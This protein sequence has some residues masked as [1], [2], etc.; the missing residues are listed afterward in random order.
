[1]RRRLLPKQVAYLLGHTTADQVRRFESHQRIPSLSTAIKLEL[2]YGIPVK[3]LFADLAIRLRHQLQEQI[4]SSRYLQNHHTELAAELVYF[5]EFCGFREKLKQETLTAMEKK[6]VRGHI[7]TLM[8]TLNN[9]D[10]ELTKK[11]AYEAK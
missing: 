9:L 11:G 5:A 1:M 7:T 6:L 4:L 2:I 10:N 8:Q 3:W